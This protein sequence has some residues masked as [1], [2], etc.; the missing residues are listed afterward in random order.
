MQITFNSLSVKQFILPVNFQSIE[1]FCVL[2]GRLYW[3]LFSAWSQP[4]LT[5]VAHIHHNSLKL[6]SIPIFGFFP[7]KS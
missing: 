6:F 5:L 7:Q 1:D 2:I 4:L 3:S